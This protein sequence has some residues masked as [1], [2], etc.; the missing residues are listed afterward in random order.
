MLLTVFNMTAERLIER[1]KSV[2]GRAL[3]MNGIHQ[4]FNHMT[5]IKSNF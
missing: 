3:N 2:V 4:V 5:F 1:T